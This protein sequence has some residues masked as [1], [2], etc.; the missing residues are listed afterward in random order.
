MPDQLK[1][2][3][4]NR[5]RQ[6]LIMSVSQHAI[7]QLTISG[8]ATLTKGAGVTAV[9]SGMAQHVVSNPDIIS[10]ADLGI[11][12]GISGV[13]IGAATN[14]IAQWR[15]DKRETRLHNE[16]LKNMRKGP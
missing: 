13:V 16:Q 7:E 3:D 8:S 4:H 14:M 6:G 2:E 10:L 12:V 5:P 15:R 9:A 1:R 11:V